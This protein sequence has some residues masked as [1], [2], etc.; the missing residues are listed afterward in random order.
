M[1]CRIPQIKRSHRSLLTL[2]CGPGSSACFLLHTENYK[3]SSTQMHRF[4]RRDG[5]L[6]HEERLDKYCILGTQAWDL[7]DLAS[8]LALLLPNCLVRVC[9]V[10]AAWTRAVGHTH[11]LLGTPIRQCTT[12]GTI[13][14]NW[15]K[16]ERKQSKD[17]RVRNQRNPY[18]RCSKCH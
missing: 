6:T 12:V 7:R 4:M 14:P 11:S 10:P 15:E 8:M 16:S 3:N 2:V 18:P 13:L 9:S 17:K 1:R 5:R